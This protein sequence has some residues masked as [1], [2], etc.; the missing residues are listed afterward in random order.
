[1]NLDQA[2]R[3]ET[4][5]KYAVFAALS[6]IQRRVCHEAQIV[7]AEGCRMDAEKQLRE[8]Q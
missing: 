5:G 4:V 3:G 7:L 6:D 8:G 1:M 2:I